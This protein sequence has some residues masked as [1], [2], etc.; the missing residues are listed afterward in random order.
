M[1]P[2]VLTFCSVFSTVTLHKIR[3]FLHILDDEP[4]KTFS[5]G[6]SSITI[7]HKIKDFAGLRPYLSS[8]F[9]PLLVPFKDCRLS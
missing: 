8:M 3:T 5:S 1:K 6:Q 2:I 4:M 9:T 7:E